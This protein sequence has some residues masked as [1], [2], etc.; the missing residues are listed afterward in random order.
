MAFFRTVSF[1]ES[2]PAVTGPGVALR[3]PQASDYPA[4]ATPRRMLAMARPPTSA[5]SSLR[6]RKNG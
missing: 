4:W 1:S 5:P 6:N 3:I 2:L